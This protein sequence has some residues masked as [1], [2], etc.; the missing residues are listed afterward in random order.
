M[1][2]VLLKLLLGS[3]LEVHLE[4]SLDQGCLHGLLAC[5]DFE[6]PLDESDNELGLFV[7]AVP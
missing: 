6:V 4:E 1:R 5:V 3:V 7:L 2:R